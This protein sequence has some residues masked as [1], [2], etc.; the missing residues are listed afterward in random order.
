MFPIMIAIILSSWFLKLLLE[1]I[2]K[3]TFCFFS[4]VSILVLEMKL[5]H[6]RISGYLWGCWVQAQLLQMRKQAQRDG[7]AQ[8]PNFGKK[9]QDPWIPGSFPSTRRNILCSVYYYMCIIYIH[10]VFLG[11]HPWHM[12]VPRL[13]PNSYILAY[14]HHGHSNSRFEPRLWPTPQLTATLD[15]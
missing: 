5:W 12:E 8:G 3:I 9:I 4:R 13:N 7:I 11:P 10:M 14:I 1:N 2:L 15:P 6:C